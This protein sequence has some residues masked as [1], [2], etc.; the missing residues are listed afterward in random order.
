MTTGIVGRWGLECEA[1]GGELG[2]CRT[3][4]RRARG[5]EADPHRPGGGLHL[6]GSVAPLVYP[7]AS[8][9][10]HRAGHRGDTAR[11]ESNSLV[12]E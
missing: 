12:A 11:P 7:V 2:Q 6:E 8:Y 1:Q 4:G 3:E 9:A 5:A 10:V